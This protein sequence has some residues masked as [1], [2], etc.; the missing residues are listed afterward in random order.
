MLPYKAPFQPWAT[1]VAL[2]ASC[3]ICFFKGYDTFMPKFNSTT[4][5]TS[6]LGIP[7]YLLMIAGAKIYYG[8]DSRVIPS[9]MDLI[10]GTRQF[11][12]EEELSAEKAALCGESRN[13]GRWY[14]RVW[15]YT[16]GA[17]LG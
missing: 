7:L 13:S 14:N 5:V 16:G 9:E 8:K 15:A 1:W 4:F 10:M 17:L 11:S 3:I 2:I 12:E 6:Y